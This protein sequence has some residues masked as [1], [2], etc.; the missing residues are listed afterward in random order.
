MIYVLIL[1]SPFSIHLRF[2]NLSYGKV[3]N[4]NYVYFETEYNLQKIK[5]GLYGTDPRKLE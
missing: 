5:K 3:L 4:D 2:F 1:I